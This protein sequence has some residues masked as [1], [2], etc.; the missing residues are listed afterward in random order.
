METLQQYVPLI[1]AETDQK[2]HQILF[3]G[4]HL[5]AARARGCAELREV[6]TDSL[7]V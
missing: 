1:G 5:T 2:A 6:P 3:G 7:A 4:D